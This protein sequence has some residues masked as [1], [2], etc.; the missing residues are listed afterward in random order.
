[1]AE[2]MVVVRSL[3]RRIEVADVW[4]AASDLLYDGPLVTNNP[5][6]NAGVAGVKLLPNE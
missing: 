3:G 5:S 1:M 2:I 6:E 4:I